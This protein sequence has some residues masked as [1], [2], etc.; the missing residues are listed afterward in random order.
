MEK[1]GYVLKGWQNSFLYGNHSKFPLNYL[2]KYNV[3]CV[4]RAYKFIQDKC[5]KVTDKDKDMNI[6]KNE[7]LHS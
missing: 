5:T 3:K 4:L 6:N 1:R 2:S 7:I